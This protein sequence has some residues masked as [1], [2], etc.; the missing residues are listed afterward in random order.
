[1]TFAEFSENIV[2]AI[3]TAFLVLVIRIV[4]D[5]TTGYDIFK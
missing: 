5:A 1:M 4:I 2:L 3:G